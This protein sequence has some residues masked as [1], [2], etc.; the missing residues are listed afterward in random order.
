M[1]KFQDY[2]I[3]IMTIVFIIYLVCALFIQFKVLYNN[4]PIIIYRNLTDSEIE[5]KQVAEYLNKWFKDNNC[6]SNAVFFYNEQ[7]KYKP[8]TIWC[9]KV[10][11][12]PIYIEK[13]LK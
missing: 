6:S 12:E 7:Y 8:N 4:E 13:V 1:G 3:N 2:L 9:N 5:N 11:T 10:Q